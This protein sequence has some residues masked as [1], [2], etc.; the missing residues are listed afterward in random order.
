MRSGESRFLNRELSWL[1]FNRRVLEEAANHANPLLERLKFL[2]I[3]ESNLDEFYMVRVSGI[4]EQFE[5]GELATTPDGLTPNNQLDLIAGTA[6]P[7]RQRAGRILEDDIRPLMEASGIYLRR[8]ADLS[9]KRRRALD[10]Q[11]AAELFPLITPLVLYPAPSVPFISNRSMNLA[12]LVSDGG[13][14]PRLARVKVPEGVARFV[15]VARRRYE[16]ILVEDLITHNLQSLFPGVEIL[17]AWPFRVIRDA[18]VEARAIESADVMASIEETL[19]LRRFGAPV[20]LQFAAEMPHEVRDRLA[21]LLELDATDLFPITGMLGFEAFWELARIDK[22]ALRFTPFVPHSYESVA[23][24]QLY[25]TVRQGDLL[26]HHPYDSFRSVEEFVA[27]AAKDPAVVGIKGTLYRVG[28]ESPIV[29]SLLEAAEAGKQVAATVELRA[30]FDESNNMGWARALERAGV[31]VTFGLPE[32]KTHSKL[33]LTVRREGGVIRRY[34]HIGTGNYNPST[35]RL[36]TDLGLFTDDEEICQDISELFNYL[37]GFSKHTNYRKLLVAPVNLR[38]GILERI[39]RE[40][41]LKKDGEI[42][43]KLNAL[44]DPEMI[45]ALY[46]AHAAGARVTLIVRGVCCLRPGVPGLSEGIRVVS[47]VGRLLEHSRVYWFGN[48]GHPD[49][50]IGSADLM[51]R[52]LD[53]R[54]ET[55]VPIEEP[56]IQEYLCHQVLMPA[57][58]D[59][60]RAWDLQP[61]GTYV[62]HK[63]GEKPFDSQTY[64]LS[65][66]AVPDT[67]FR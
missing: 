14:E 55:L 41:R 65:H 46:S 31:H 26:V 59:N 51:R 35:A 62:R 3:F 33:F 63:D 9:Q 57:L 50:L 40:A 60:V 30:R 36:Y 39:R 34:A 64:L 48:G 43:F 6:L 61:D 27:S 66:P 17:G 29:E 10:Q 24:P 8:Y 16:Y 53:R 52:N 44:V 12:V 13:T 4:I 32:L 42:L 28:K 19:R 49:V 18:D 56:R 1:Q 11:F 20:L 25:D 54:I 38:Q 5:S 37:T 21:G 47:V 67:V 58:R 22:P 15:K 7:Q 45:E 2:A 23:G